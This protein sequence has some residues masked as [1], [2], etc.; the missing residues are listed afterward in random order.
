MNEGFGNRFQPF[1]DFVDASSIREDLIANGISPAEAEVA[2]S[3]IENTRAQMLV[4]QAINELSRR[5]L[6]QVVIINPLKEKLSIAQEEL[7]RINKVLDSI[8]RPPLTE[9][10]K[11]DQMVYEIMRNRQELYTSNRDTFLGSI[12][13]EPSFSF[14]MQ[15][16]PV[17][18]YGRPQKPE[19]HLDTYINTHKPSLTRVFKSTSSFTRIS[20]ILANKKDYDLLQAQGVITTKQVDDDSRRIV[21]QKPVQFFKNLLFEERTKCGP[22]SGWA[23]LVLSDMQQAEAKLATE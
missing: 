13:E 5:A 6:E 12:A 19:Y 7:S 11:I 3:S 2:S 1:L 10:E 22:I 16:S 4:D 17:Y 20:N 23:L 18:N 14:T 9:T 8:G 15:L 21:V